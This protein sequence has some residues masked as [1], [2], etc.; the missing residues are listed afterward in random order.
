MRIRD[1]D[2]ELVRQRTDLVRLVQQYV[3]LKKAGADRFVGLCPFHT[4]KTPS[5]GVSPSKGMYYCH[6]CGRGGDAFRFIQDI[7]GLEFVEG[8]ER[9]A[10]HAGVTLRYEGVSPGQRRQASRRQALHRATAMAADLYRRMLLE[11]REA[12]AAR[13][14]IEERGISRQSVETFGIGFAPGYPDFLLRRMAREFSPEILVEAGLAAK[15]NRGGV[16]DRFR[17]RIMFPIHD[18]SGNAVGFGARLLEGD[19]PKYLNSPETPIYRK[20]E[21]LYNL[22]RAKGEVTK[23]GRAFVV[24]GYTDVIALHQAG[25]PLAVATCGTALGE[26][27]FRVLS[28]FSRTAVLCFD[29]DEAGARA[30]ER[31]HGLFERFALD[32]SV[33]I[34]PEGQDPADFVTRE[35][36]EAFD[37]LAD[38]A[39]PLVDYMLQRAVR[40]E[41]LDT[42]EGKARAVR[43]ALPIVVGLN[44]PVLRGQYA[45]RLADLV[46]VS[47]TDISLELDGAEGPGRQGPGPGEEAGR[48]VEVRTPAREV[49]K[50]A[51]KVLA[52]VP[53]IGSRHADHISEE[54]FTTERYRKAWALLEEAPGD[55]AALADRAGARGQ[56]ELIA[57]LTLEPLKGEPTAAYA[58]RLFA[59]LEELRLRREVDTMK[60]RLETLNPVKEPDTFDELFKQ[61]A[62]VTGRWRDARTRAGEGA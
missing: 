33:L 16:R 39:D 40:G 45:G 24:E 29:A 52:Q 44:D 41:A 4:E 13:R 37:R 17:T 57:E 61:L 19:G 53:D 56:A 46:G 50:E 27:H 35:G 59:R 60:K 15:D 34:L 7:E 43:A 30:A 48:P 32:V 5:F 42:P 18:L 36:A 58:E 51:L 25:I 62:D 3:A 55:P 49:E 9:L 54:H 8:V 20:G 11:G 2:K 31:A 6:G 47:P 12:E 23:A 1:D 38:G 14:Y 22:N 21:L 10:A 28:R 26:G